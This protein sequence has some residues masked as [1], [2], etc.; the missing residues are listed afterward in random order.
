MITKTVVG[1]GHVG[2][3]KGYCFSVFFNGRPYPNFISALYR[4]AKKA[5]TML[6]VYVETGKFDWYGDAE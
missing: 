6:K 4:K 5:K 3:K 2:N 1:Q